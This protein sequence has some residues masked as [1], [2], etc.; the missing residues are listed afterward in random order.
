MTNAEILKYIHARCRDDAACWVWCGA[1]TRDITPNMRYPG[2]RGEPPRSVRGIVL[3]ASGQPRPT[4]KHR[5]S[6]NCGNSLCVAPK[7][8]A[9][10]TVQERQ[11][12]LAA[13]GRYSSLSR[14]I[15]KARTSQARSRWTWDDI[16]AMRAKHAAGASIPELVAEFGMKRSGVHR[17]VNYKSWIEYHANPFAGL[18]TGLAANDAGGRKRA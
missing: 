9:W 1:V 5:A 8:A 17:V 14:T 10:L 3:E 4:P 6:P 12:Q 7:H 18:F 16:R 11:Q 2:R 15:Q 13:Q